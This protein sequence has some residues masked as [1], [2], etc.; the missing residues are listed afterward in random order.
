MLRIC[1]WTWCV[2]TGRVDVATFGS[3]PTCIQVLDLCFCYYSFQTAAE[4]G[5]RLSWLTSCRRF[6]L[7]S[8]AVVSRAEVVGML[9]E[10]LILYGSWKV[11]WNMLQ[12]SG[13]DRKDTGNNWKRG[14]SVWCIQHCQL[15]YSLLHYLKCILL[16]FPSCTTL[17]T[18]YTSPVMWIACIRKYEK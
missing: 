12:T 6:I 14:A 11:L 13:S 16:S 17:S 2:G 8:A 10:T 1:V 4:V 18:C 7:K 3:T 5:H 15:I 9:V